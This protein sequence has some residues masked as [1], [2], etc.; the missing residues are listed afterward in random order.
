MSACVEGRNGCPGPGLYCDLCDYP[1][2]KQPRPG[3]T[4]AER[5]RA[6]GSDPGLLP[7]WKPIAVGLSIAE[8]HPE[9]VDLWKATEA[10]RKAEAAGHNP[11]A[12]WIRDA[13]IADGKPLAFDVLEGFAKALRA[14]AEVSAYGYEK[15]TRRA[16]E[17]LMK[18]E[19]A[20][21]AEAEVAIPY[22]NWRNGN[23][24]TY[25]N[26]MMRHILDRAA[27]ETHAPDS[28]LRHRAHEAW[29][30]LAALALEIEAEE[31]AKAIDTP[32]VS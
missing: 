11:G 29:N 24:R 1:P 4:T 7:A 22:N 26:A 2:R 5:A 21:Q 15:H 16:R 19:G 31:R 3:D 27:G 18:E 32:A 28:K 12:Q 6:E 14:V 20:T 30:A 23:V 9:F 13:K 10:R 8:T 25:D 17:R